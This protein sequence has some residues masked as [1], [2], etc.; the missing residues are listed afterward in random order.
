MKNI[1]SI[2]G[3]T[4]LSTLSTIAQQYP[5]GTFPN[6]H[7]INGADYPRIGTDKR[8][9]FKIYAPEAKKVEISFRGEMTKQPDG[10]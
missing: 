4:L 7:N 2:L 10:Y 9:H 3:F 5:A 1:L 6:E 8:V